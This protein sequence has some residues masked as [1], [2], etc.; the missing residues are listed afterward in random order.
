MF[1]AEQNEQ[2]SFYKPL[3]LSDLSQQALF[4]IVKKVENWFKLQK[5]VAHNSEKLFSL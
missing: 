1:L 3:F 5:L 4:R 2:Q